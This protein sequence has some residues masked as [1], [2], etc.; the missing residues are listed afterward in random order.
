MKKSIALL[1]TCF[2]TVSLIAKSKAS[3]V[4]FKETPNKTICIKHPDANKPTFFAEVKTLYFEVYKPDTKA[5]IVNIVDK[6][7]KDP[8]VQS[9]NVGKQ[10]GDYYAI[11]LILKKPADKNWFITNFKALGLKTI[12]LNNAEVTEVDKL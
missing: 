2:L 3:F 11:Q 10:T 5:D 7:S 1:I 8:Q 6:L 4:L 9:C 12:K